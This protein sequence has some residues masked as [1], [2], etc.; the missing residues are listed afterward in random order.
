MSQKIVNGF[1]QFY[2]LTHLVSEFYGTALTQLS[3]DHTDVDLQAP[4]YGDQISVDVLDIGLLTVTRDG[5]TLYLDQGFEIV[6]PNVLRVF[7]GLLDGETLQFKKLVGASGLIETIPTV[8][9]V[10]GS[11]G[12][13][14]EILEATIYTDD[15]VAAINAFSPVLLAGKTRIST[16]F[17]LN[18]GKIDVFLNGSRVSVND[19]IWF[20]ADSTT[21]ELD[22][23]YSTTKMKVDI[24][25]QKVG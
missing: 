17:A 7:P 25:R 14:Q 12:Y 18:E 24:T 1:P 2:A 11:G 5:A 13:A 21:I 16:H 3:Q 9:P 10:P 23:N 20:F 19:G 15:S 6:A 4:Q 22:D 8:P